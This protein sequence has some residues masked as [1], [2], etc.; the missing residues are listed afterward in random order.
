MSYRVVWTSEARED[1]LELWTLSSEK[2]ALSRASE[3]INEILSNE[4]F[5]E[6]HE[7][8]DDRGSV[9]RELLGVDFRIDSSNRVV[10]VISAWQMPE[11]M[12]M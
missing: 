7:V 11:N 8:Y 3:R 6:R 12:G 2:A 4:P 10:T 5:A 9:I 1:F